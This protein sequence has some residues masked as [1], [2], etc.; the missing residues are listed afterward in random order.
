MQ[1]NGTGTIYIHE[2][3]SSN[4]QIYSDLNLNEGEIECPVIIATKDP[5]KLNFHLSSQNARLSD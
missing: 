2:S 1:I 3:L 5:Q 4:S